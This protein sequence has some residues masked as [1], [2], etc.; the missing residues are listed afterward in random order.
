[1]LTGIND[2]GTAIGWT[3]YAENSSEGFAMLYDVSNGNM[4]PL[5]SAKGALNGVTTGQINNNGW[6]VGTY[7]DA[8]GKT[9]GF[10]AEPVQ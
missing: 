9:H 1:M 6:F 5:I 7:Y 10:Y 4:T 8:K 2:S 3:T